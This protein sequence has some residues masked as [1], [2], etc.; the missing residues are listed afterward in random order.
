MFKKELERSD[1]VAMNK[2][3]MMEDLFDFVFTVTA[4]FFLLFFV[5]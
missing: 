4:L 2:K 1:E 3:G 5:F